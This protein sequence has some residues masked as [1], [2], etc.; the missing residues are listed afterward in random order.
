MTR[1]SETLQ[2]SYNHGKRFPLV[3]ILHFM[4]WPY[5]STFCECHNLGRRATPTGTAESWENKKS[6]LLYTGS[7][8]VGQVELYI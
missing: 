5:T 3:N 2:E 4:K 6:K 7:W 8:F 1:C